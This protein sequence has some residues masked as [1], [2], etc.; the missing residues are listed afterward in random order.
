M[1]TTPKRKIS[2]FHIRFSTDR[3]PE[4]PQ[5]FTLSG[6]GGI[7]THGDPKTTTVFETA[8]IDHSGTSPFLAVPIIAEGGLKFHSG[9]PIR[10]FY[11]P[12]TVVF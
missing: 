1:E 4:G 5:D 10:V 6:E 8:P 12:D 7:R 2:F 3:E 9:F 11:L